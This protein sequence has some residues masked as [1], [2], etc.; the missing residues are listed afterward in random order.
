[1]HQVITDELP[2]NLLVAE[3]GLKWQ[4]TRKLH[5]GKKVYIVATGIC[6][7][8]MVRVQFYCAMV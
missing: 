3:F 4:G 7:C 5:D 1:M 6:A 2:A 8:G